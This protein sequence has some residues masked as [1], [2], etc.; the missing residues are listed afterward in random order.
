MEHKSHKRTEDTNI[1]TLQSTSMVQVLESL[2]STSPYTKRKK[3][4][5][6][7]AKKSFMFGT[8]KLN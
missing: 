3:T 2:R 7:S 5:L 4:N 8:G 1:M 6:M